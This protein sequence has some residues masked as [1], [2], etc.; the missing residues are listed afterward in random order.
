MKLIQV[1][2]TVIIAGLYLFPFKISFIPWGNTK[3]MLAVIG[4]F[5]LVYDAAT[6]RVTKSALND[7]MA[8]S[9]LAL[10]V[11]LCGLFGVVL[12]NTSDYSYAGYIFSMWVWLA[13]SYL[14][15]C[16]IN[17]A[18]GQI[19]FRLVANYMIAVCV[20]QCL[21]SIMND[22]IPAFKKVVD[23]YVFQGQDF[24]NSLPGIKRKYG[25]GANLDTAGVRFSAILILIPAT[26]IG[27]KDELKRKWLWAYALSF[28][29]I[30]IEGNIISRTTIVGT[31]MG[32]VY[33]LF[34]LNKLKSDSKNFN[35]WMSLASV[36]TL[37]LI[38]LGG[39]YYYNVNEGF[40][41]DLRFGFEGLFSLVEN[42]EWSVSS[43]DRLSNMYV[44]PENLQ[45]WLIGDGYFSNPINTDPYFIGKI[46]GG[47][48]MGTDVGFLRFIFYFGVIGLTAFAL[49]FIGCGIL[50]SKEYPNHRMF[51]V[52]LVILGY[53][54]WFKVATDLF[55]IFALFLAAS[56]LR[57][58]DKQKVES[59]I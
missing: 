4:M 13:A 51:F 18:H 49:F 3:L 21:A 32:L 41:E 52:L 5:L 17:N 59:C 37:G 33:I 8:V 24:I 22:N 28:L 46:T 47:Y 39:I 12:N 34:N 38:L 27:L 54:V 40:R 35:S 42:G 57:S 56:I 29:F 14:V 45:T 58:S 55:L 31:C 44:W 50:C 11:S 53:I 16:L 23:T 30:T 48:Y 26:V 36:F 1:V 2:F 15:V 25:I 10:I 7:S 6:N 20:I 43:N 9:L 19:N